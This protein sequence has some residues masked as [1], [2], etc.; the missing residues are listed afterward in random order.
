VSEPT[1]AERAVVA[2]A[3]G[4]LG[5][6]PIDHAAAASVSDWGAALDLAERHMV[7]PALLRFIQIT[8]PRLGPDDEAR[9]REGAL[10]LTQVSLARAAELRR[11]ADALDADGVGWLAVK[12]PVLATM[13]FG[14][15]AQ[16][17]YADLDLVVRPGALGA[18]ARALGPLGYTPDPALAHVLAWPVAV[19]VTFTRPGGPCPLDVQTSLSHRLGFGLDQAGLW[20]RA[21]RVRVAGREVPTLGLAD[22]AHYLAV[23]GAQHGWE[24]LSWILD[25]AACVGAPVPWGELLARAA[26]FHSRRMV[27][28]AAA[29]AQD[30]LGATLPAALSGPVDADPGLTVS[31]ARVRRRLFRDDLP[32]ARLVAGRYA[33]QLTAWDDPAA[34]LRHLLRVVGSPTPNDY[35]AARLPSFV[36]GAYPLVR[37]ARKARV[38]G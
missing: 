22:T 35:G 25:F 18:V 33:L 37:W 32:E 4:A 16:R 23:H 26:A 30:L 21:Q 38:L 27:L 28:L 34:T 13:V 9:L 19:T 17:Q 12:G 2:A 8:R 15:V 29:I 36:R 24:R 1:P 5:V 14:G 20:S 10:R 31:V 3:R 11:V 7:L 6:D